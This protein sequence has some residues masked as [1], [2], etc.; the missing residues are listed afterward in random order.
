MENQTDGLEKLIY[1]PIS[2]RIN[3]FLEAGPENEKVLIYHTKVF[4]K[5]FNLCKIK[6]T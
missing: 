4:H 1:S 2:K 5:Y 6:L 3:K